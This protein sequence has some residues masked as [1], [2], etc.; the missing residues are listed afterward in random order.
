MGGYATWKIVLYPEMFA[1]V[2]S[3]C[4]GVGCIVER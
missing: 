4:G 1:A 3:I 2:V